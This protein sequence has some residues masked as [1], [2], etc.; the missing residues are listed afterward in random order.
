MTNKPR[1]IFGCILATVVMA[2]A[3][4]MFYPRYSVQHAG[5]LGACHGARVACLDRAILADERKAEP[6]SAKSKD[7]QP[8][9]K[10][11]DAPR[12]NCNFQYGGVGCFLRCLWPY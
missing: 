9:A 1:I 7:T 3:L 4:T 12:A 2:P 5:C 10:E 6:S 11:F 8:A